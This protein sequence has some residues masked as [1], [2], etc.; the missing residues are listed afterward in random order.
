VKLATLQLYTGSQNSDSRSFKRQVN[1]ALKELVAVGFLDNYR[2][3]KDLVT[4]WR[5]T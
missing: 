1:R 3:D 2:L 4:V 5:K